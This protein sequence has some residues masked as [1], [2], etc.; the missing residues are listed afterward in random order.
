MKRFIPILFLIIILISI[1]AFEE[2]YTNKF[3]KD[4]D[5]KAGIV[6]TKIEENKDN[7]NIETVKTSYNDLNT[8]WHKAKNTLCFFTNY[9]KIRNI[10]ESFVKLSTAITNN[11][12]SLATENATV[13]KEYSTFFEYLMGFNINNLF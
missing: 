4:L 7:L 13:I 3:M 12:L 9:E 6:L 1:A 2:F 10:D 8:F 11:D 5:N